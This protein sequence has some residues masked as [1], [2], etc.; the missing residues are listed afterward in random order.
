MHIII[1]LISVPIVLKQNPN[2]KQKA[3]ALKIISFWHKIIC[4]ILNIKITTS[5]KKPRTSS[6]L[7][8][9]HIS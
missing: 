7:V 8:A 4:L 9:N 1:G 2:E 3:R 5:G 6:L